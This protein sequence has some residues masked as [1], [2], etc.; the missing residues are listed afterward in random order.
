MYPRPKTISG[1]DLIMPG[2]VAV[3][4]KDG[5]VFVASMKTGS[6][7]VLNDPSGDAQQARFDDYAHGLFQEAYSMLADADGLYVLH[8]RNLTRI[9]ES[10]PG[11]ADRFERIAP[12]EQGI[13]DTYDYGY[14]LVR[15][16]S[17]AFVFTQAPHADRRLPGAG[18]A[19]RLV[20]GQKAKEIAFG[21]RNPLG[22]CTGL[23]GEIFFTDNQGEWVATNKLCHLEEDQFHGY[24][25]HEQKQH[26]QRKAAKTTVWVPYAWAKSINGVACDNT[27]G[28]FGPFAGQ[29]FM[30]ELMFGGAII[31]ADVEK[32]NGIYQG[33]C[34]PFWGTGLLGPVTLAFDPKG[35]LYVGSI[36]EP[37][38]MAQPDRGALFRIDPTGRIPFEMQTIRVLPNGFRVRFTQPVSVK[39]AN[40]LSSYRIESFRYEYTGAYGSPELD[41]S[42]LAIQSIQVAA[43][44]LSADLLTA[45]LVK[46]RVYLIEARGVRSEKGEALVHPL[47]AYTLNEIPASRE[48]K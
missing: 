30:A 31:R 4:P 46:D 17:G 33:A 28:K 40:V 5:R 10:K 3:N 47:G 22:W 44:G 34:F 29:F 8:R 43:D 36:T 11:R 20:P 18:N 2:A 25:N 21:F 45:P 38:W 6:L 12:V 41:R 32:V 23:E 1:E 42:P 7:F 27:D 15:D 19:L 14:G 9:S 26:A 24:P 39:T 35:R 16:K 48:R 13:A 37:G